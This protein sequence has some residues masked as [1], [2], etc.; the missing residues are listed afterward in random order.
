[1][2]N[3]SKPTE[4]EGEDE[5]KKAV[6]EP[7]SQPVEEVVRRYSR[8]EVED[9]EERYE[10]QDEVPYPQGEEVDREGQEL[11]DRLHEGVDHPQE[12]GRH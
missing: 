4:N 12:E 9:E 6:E 7:G 5:R 10:V 11:E 2:P 3:I 1:M 8:D